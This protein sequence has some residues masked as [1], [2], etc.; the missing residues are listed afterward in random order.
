MLTLYKFHYFIIDLR[1]LKALTLEY[2][3]P[4]LF[5]LLFTGPVNVTAYARYELPSAMGHML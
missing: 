3:N 5:L 1:I 4:D 2:E